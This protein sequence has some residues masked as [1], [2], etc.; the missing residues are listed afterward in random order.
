MN[1]RYKFKYRKSYFPFWKTKEV[2]GH[3]IEYVEDSILDPNGNTVQKIKK[4]QDA[5]ILYYENGSIERIG[6]WSSYDLFLG[7]DWVLV[8]KDSMQ[9]EVGQNIP[10]NI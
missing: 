6:N 4:P 9:R 7:I 2:I 10:F 8:T 1:K 3:S 5:M